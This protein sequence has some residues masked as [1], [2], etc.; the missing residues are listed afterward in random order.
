[1]SYFNRLIYSQYPFYHPLIST[2]LHLS[3]I[4]LPAFLYDSV[5]L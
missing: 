5:I 1:M 3:I 4:F 2:E